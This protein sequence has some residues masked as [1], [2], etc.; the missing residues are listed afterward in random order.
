VSGR[1]A[2]YLA[3]HAIDPAIAEE[4]GVRVE[5]DALIFPGGRVRSLNGAGPEVRQ[6][7]G[8]P[9]AAWWPRGRPDEA[10]LVLVTEGESDGLAAV[11]WLPAT[12]DCAGLR[13]LPVVAIPGTGF[14]IARLVEELCE[15]GAH[16]VVL[17]LDADRAGRTYL[18]RAAAAL[19]EQGIRPVPLELRDGFDLAA[20]LAAIEPSERGE[21]LADAL[22]DAEAAAPP[23]AAENPSPPDPDATSLHFRA[24][25]EV[26]AV[27]PLAP[28]WVLGGYIARGL[29]TML[30]GKPKAGKSTL[31]CAIAEAVDAEVEAFLGREV[32]GGRVVYVSE[33]GPA[34]LAAKL[35][36]STGSL[37]LSRDDAWPKPGWPELIAAAVRKAG[38]IGAVLLVIDALAFWAGFAEGAEK[39]SGAAQA[40]MDALGAATG[41]G[42][43]VLIVHHQR[44]AG[45]EEGDAVRGSG[46]IFGAVDVLIEVERLGEAA[47]PRHRRLV[48]VGRFPGA[49]PPVLVIERERECWRVVGEADTRQGAA[50][51][52]MRGR[53]LAAL[54]L[55]EPVTETELCELVGTDKRK[56]GPPLRELVDEGLVERSGAGKRGDPYRY[57]KVSQKVSPAGTETPVAKVSSPVGGTPATNSVQGKLS[58]SG[59]ESEGQPDAEASRGAGV[60]GGDV[61]HEGSPT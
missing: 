51:L 13:G 42:L 6:P 34:T 33:E 27:A 23:D 30:A 36:A 3:E 35:P 25:A 5:S 44:K 52:G 29:V 55:G 7:K 28:P 12:P 8:R 37:A 56:T 14:P 57:E 2:A 38:E 26:R 54:P 15:V 60:R 19:R 53:V 40:V 17:G 59:T 10:S 20:W 49:T 47:D 4:V 61:A 50:A 45:G 18:H 46:A 43:A 41:S 48:A 9:L 21:R 1:A 11:S 16:E 24:W 32:A 39:D 31:A 58:P 22:V